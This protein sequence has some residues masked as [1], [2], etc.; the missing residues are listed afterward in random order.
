MS[1]SGITGSNLTPG[2]SSSPGFFLLEEEDEKPSFLLSE[3][4][5]LISL[6]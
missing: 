5:G 6:I 4:G 3:N 2:K 1:L